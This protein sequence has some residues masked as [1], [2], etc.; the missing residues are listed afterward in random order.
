MVWQPGHWLLS[1]N[2]WTWHPGQY[3]AP[4]VG[5]TTWVP[6]QWVAQPAGGYRWVDGHWG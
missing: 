2:S 4:P 6:G 1:G 5:G 3:V